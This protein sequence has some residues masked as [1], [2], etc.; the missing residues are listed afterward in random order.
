MASASALDDTHEKCSGTKL[1]RLLIDGGT[2]TLRRT[3]DSIRPPANLQAVLRTNQ[4]LLNTLRKKRVINTSQWDILYPPGGA[5]PDSKAFDITLL[6]VLLRNICGLTAP[7]TGWDALPPAADVSRKAN[8][9]R[10][11]YYRNK[12]YGHVTSTGVS[13]TDF[14]M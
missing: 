12:L 8:L 1:A 5:A 4:P 13:E 14:Y 6:C 10:I 11:K 9:A 7:A 2:E 3:F